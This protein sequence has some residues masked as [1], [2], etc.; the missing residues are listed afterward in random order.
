MRRFQL[1]SSLVGPVPLVLLALVAG[2]EAPTGAE[3]KFSY[4][5][6]ALTLSP[7]SFLDETVP[8]STVSVL[9]ETYFGLTVVDPYIRPIETTLED[10]T[11]NTYVFE[12]D[13]AGTDLEVPVRQSTSFG[14]RL[15]PPSFGIETLWSSGT[16][17]TTL[18]FTVVGNGTIDEATGEPDPGAESRVPVSIPVSVEIVCDHDGDGYDDEACY[19]GQD[20]DDTLPAVNPD[21]TEVCDGAD[22]DCSGVID[23]DCIEP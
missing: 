13:P 16:Y 8:F 9:N 17:T 15:R 21:A 10:G 6:Q 20:C 23:D 11:P 19:G 3:A 4:G 14:V 2:C 7:V 12:I 18:Q 22:N 5:P 1:P